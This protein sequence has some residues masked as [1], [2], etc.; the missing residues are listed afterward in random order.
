MPVPLLLFLEDLDDLVEVGV[1]LA[2]VLALGSHVAVVEAVEGTPSFS[3]NSK[4][5]RTR[6][7]AMSTESVPSSQGRT[8]QPGP[9]GSPPMPRK[10]CQ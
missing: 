4:A 1:G 8:A 3:M 10:V 9:N 5:T 2:Q 6:L 7:I